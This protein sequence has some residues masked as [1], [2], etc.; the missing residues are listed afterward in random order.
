MTPKST[1]E[2]LLE[3]G[4][5]LIALH[6]VTAV[7]ARKI[8]EEAGAANHSA[9]AYHFGTKLDL[10]LEVVR[11]HRAHTD[12][13]G[14]AMIEK[15]AGS[16]D[17]R[18]HLACV[19]LPTLVHLDRL[20]PPTYYARFAAQTLSDPTTEP[21][22]I[23]E[24]A[25]THMADAM[26]A[27]ARTTSDIPKEVMRMRWRLVRPLMFRASASF[28]LDLAEGRN[29]DGTWAHLGRF[30]LDAIGGLLLAPNTLPPEALRTASPAPAWLHPDL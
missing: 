21:H 3:A 24:L 7:S 2:L 13:I 12:E 8:A 23:P 27:V 1:R 14:R 30:M 16:A 5:R 26:R 15:A 9:V 17:P 10:I 18:E 19:L 22:V 29:T 6:G 25:G 11:A 4:E 28:E 20:G